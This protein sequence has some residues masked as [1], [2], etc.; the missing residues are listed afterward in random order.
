MPGL[1]DLI[2]LIKSYG[3]SLAGWVM[4]FIFVGWI[5]GKGGKLAMS[6]VK[7]LLDTGEDLRSRM[8]NSLDEYERQIRIRDALISELK[9][10]AETARRTMAQMH[11]ELMT[12]KHNFQIEMLTMQEELHRLTLELREARAL[13]RRG[14]PT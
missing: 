1:S 2:D 8:K 4:L 7:A 5:A 10:D 12:V 14:D 6:N 11:E 3:P 13:R 9:S